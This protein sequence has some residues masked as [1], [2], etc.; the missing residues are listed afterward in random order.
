[1]T[2]KTII[3]LIAVGILSAAAMAQAP[4]GIV[5]V[6]S[7]IGHLA[8]QNSILAYKRDN[9]GR[10]NKFGE[11]PTS[12]TG[13]HPLGIELGNL[14]GT[15]GPFD[16]DQNLIL[17]AAGTRLY[18]VNSGS[19]TIAVFDVRAD[20]SLVPVKGSP[21]PS[22]GTN[23][24]SVGLADDE[25]VL[26]VVNQDYDIVRPGFDVS[27]RAPNHTAFRINANGKLIQIPH[28][29][30][31]A[32]QGG[33]IGPGNPTPSQALVVPGGRLVIDADSFG[34]SITSFKVGTNGR[35]EFASSADTP[36]SEF[37]AFPGLP[38]PSG[39]PLVLGLAAHPH[40]P[41]FYAGF[42][43][44]LPGR[45]AVYTYDSTGAV[46]F[47]RSVSADLGTC[48]IVINKAGDRVYAI[49]TLVNTVTVLDTSDPLNPV[50]LENFQLAGP[51]S[52]AQ[53]AALD[54]SGEYLYVVSQ[55]AVAGTPA[56]SNAVHVLKLA[57]DGKIA[58]ETDRVV[59]P[60]EPSLP[61]GVAAR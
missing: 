57:A 1:M 44:S 25:N 60:V 43:F 21:F 51:T 53:Q 29:T 58:E 5:Y 15:I 39:R 18:A 52:G 34:S 31:I 47:V 45:V 36:T 33:S 24:V 41:V 23:P 30:I 55:Q 50:N 37:V 7:N 26:V 38:I 59:I 46:Q 28:S 56:E 12:G 2:K 32:G 4:R 40:E 20:G 22:G 8:G 49:N 48:W 42:G 54:E 35:L 10:L 3:M 61:Q 19:D 11:F 14:P 27:R 16:S 6:E 13:V 9:A 17:N